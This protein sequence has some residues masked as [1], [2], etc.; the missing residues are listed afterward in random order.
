MTTKTTA[1]T[2][3]FI[4][5]S[6]EEVKEHQ[7]TFIKALRSGD[8]KQGDQRLLTVDWE[9]GE[10]V[11]KYCC[12]GVACDVSNLGVWGATVDYNAASQAGPHYSMRNYTVTNPDTG[13]AES[14]PTLMPNIVAEYYGWGGDGIPTETNPQLPDGEMSIMH[15]GEYRYI[16]MAN[17]ND[18]WNWDFNQFADVLEKEWKLNG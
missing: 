16:G 12:L 11:K 17:L 15:E 4:H 8:Y 10:P 13:Q 6:E 14:F 7:R 9:D 3:M 5:W 2:D 18:D 1:T